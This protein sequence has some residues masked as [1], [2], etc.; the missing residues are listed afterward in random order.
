MSKYSALKS[1]HEDKIETYIKLRIKE[2]IGIQ[3]Y[4]RDQVSKGVFTSQ[5]KYWEELLVL[6]NPITSKEIDKLFSDKTRTPCDGE[7]EYLYEEENSTEQNPI[8]I[9]KCNKCLH[10]VTRFHP[11]RAPVRCQNQL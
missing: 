6:L 3:K 10:L 7:Y 5:L 11:N 8:S 1:E 9:Y 2:L 4:A